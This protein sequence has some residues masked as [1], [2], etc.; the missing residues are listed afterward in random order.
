MPTEAARLRTRELFRTTSLFVVTLGLAEVWFQ[1]RKREGRAE[2][3]P[4]GRAEGR[5]A[6][7]EQ[8]QQEEEQVLWRAVPSDKFDPR[9]HGFRVSTVAENL[10]NLRRCARPR[11]CHARACHAR[12]HAHIATPRGR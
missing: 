2:G 4:E 10:N 8:Q 3:Q 5:A 7:E 6:E 9:R 11:G 1:R 12:T